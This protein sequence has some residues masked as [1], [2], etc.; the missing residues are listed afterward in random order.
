MYCTIGF[1]SGV[2]LSLSQN[3]V[4]VLEKREL[5]SILGPQLEEVT[6]CPMRSFM[7]CIQQ[8]RISRVCQ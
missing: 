5:K 7:I 4:D 2:K 6:S 8:T 3:N 1:C